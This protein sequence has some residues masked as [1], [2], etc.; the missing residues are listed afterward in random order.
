[1]TFIDVAGNE[2]YMKTLLT[3][4]CCSHPDYALVVVDSK[5][6]INVVAIDHF[7]MAFALG[8]PVI[9]VMSKIDTANEEEINTTFD[10]IK[11]LTKEI[12][13]KMIVKV[14]A[15]NDTSL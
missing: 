15:V 14:D 7:K 10:A 2:K 4:I 8:I 5:N 12:S 6:G 1:M 3:G 11:K 13:N 9:I